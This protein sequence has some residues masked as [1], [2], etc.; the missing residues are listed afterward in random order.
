MVGIEILDPSGAPAVPD[1]DGRRGEFSL[2]QCQLP[3]SNRPKALIS[4]SNVDMTRPVLSG[5]LGW[6]AT[7]ITELAW[8]YCN[9]AGAISHA[10]GFD[11][12][13]CCV[14][15]QSRTPLVTAMDDIFGT[16]KAE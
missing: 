1:E 12:P 6:W 7:D 9:L 16:Q 11:F 15:N 8:A 10:I 5:P 3:A 14:R 13:H 2:S 4:S